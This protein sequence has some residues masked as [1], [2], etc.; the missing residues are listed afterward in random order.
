MCI[1]MVDLYPFV[2]YACDSWTNSV[3]WIRVSMLVKIPVLNVEP[4]QFLVSF[5][6][7]CVGITAFIPTK[8]NNE[9]AI[10]LVRT[11]IRL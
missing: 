8:N 1:R 9:W 6:E 4:D 3:A 2:Y 10:K 7:Y 11:H 5:E